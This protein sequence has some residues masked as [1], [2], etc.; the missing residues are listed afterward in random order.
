MRSQQ[1]QIKRDVVDQLF[2]DTRIDA[3]DVTVTVSDGE[4]QLSGSLPSYAARKA[5]QKDALQVRG[6]SRVIDNTTIQTPAEV[7]KPS[8]DDILINITNL[9]KWSASIAI[10]DIDVSV[11]RGVVTLRGAVDMYWKKRKAEELAYEVVGVTGVEN[12]LVV[13]PSKTQVD[14]SI[15]EEISAALRRLG[16]VDLEDITITVDEGIVTLEGRVPD[17]VT[18]FKVM[19]AAEYTSGVVGVVNKMEI[20]TSMTVRTD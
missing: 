16:Q 17:G 9:L 20:D 1:E 15:A 2:W 6:V 19:Y 14:R 3:S 13:T 11:N 4:V 8:D 10:T 12:Q 5:A 7:Q 18:M